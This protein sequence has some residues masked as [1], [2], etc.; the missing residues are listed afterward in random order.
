VSKL[1]V[2][3]VAHR[4]VPGDPL[5]VHARRYGH[6]ILHVVADDHI[7]FARVHGAQPPAVVL[8]ASGRTLTCRGPSGTRVLLSSRVAALAFKVAKD[9][10]LP[11]VFARRMWLCGSGSLYAAAALTVAF[12]LFFPFA[13]VG[14][15]ASLAFLIVYGM[16]SLGHLRVR[17]ETGA[18]GWML[19]AAVGLNAAL[20]L[21]LLGYAVSKGPATTWVT[22]LALLALSFVA[23]WAYRRRTDRR[24]Q[25]AAA[26]AP[27][28]TSRS[29]LHGE[30][31]GGRS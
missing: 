14:Q 2:D 29:S 1:V 17:K 12:V 8:K 19:Y 9:R 23:E 4:A 20:C 31:A 10:Q 13:A 30:Q 24:L 27:D 15:M 18:R 5:L 7:C 28:T 16:V 25:P 6:A 21:L 3:R 11:G 22:L 26:A